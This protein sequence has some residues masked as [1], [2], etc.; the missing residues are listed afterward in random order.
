MAYTGY[1][2]DMMANFKKTKITIASQSLQYWYK[3]YKT[4]LFE[5][6]LALFEWD[7]HGDIP[8]RQ[9][10]KILMLNGMICGTDI[11]KRRRRD[12]LFVYP[13]TFAG[14]PTVYYDLYKSVAYSCPL[15]SGILEI[16]KKC[17]VGFNTST[18]QSVE[19]I[20]HTFA[21]I[22]AHAQV[23]IINKLINEREKYV[24]CGSSDKDI[25]MWRQYRNS[26]V[27][28][29]VSSMM[30]KGFQSIDIKTFPS[31]SGMSILEI[32]EFIRNTIEMFLQMFGIKTVHEKKGNMI[33]DEVDANDSMLIFNLVDSSTCREEF[34]DGMNK[35]YKHD[36]SFKKQECIDYKIVDRM[37]EGEG[38]AVDNDEE[39]DI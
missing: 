14:S 22:L 13:C 32:Q 10:E 19:P 11:F 8:D 39:S 31:M 25:E 16:N 21:I 27:S 30:D 26:L 38:E 9:I 3:Y 33:V 7:T 24:A 15:D 28:G 35:M 1:V 4:N 37:V 2:T 20:L 29:A 17:V 18:H 36:W 23:T 34:R 5:R 12:E 6:I